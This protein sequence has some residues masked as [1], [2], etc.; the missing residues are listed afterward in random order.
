V[1]CALR[2]K[3]I[4]HRAMELSV[5]YFQKKSKASLS[6]RERLALLSRLADVYIYHLF[7]L[8]LFPL[9]HT[10]C[11]A[12]FQNSPESRTWLCAF[13]QNLKLSK[14]CP[15]EG[16]RRGRVCEKNIYQRGSLSERMWEKSRNETAKHTVGKTEPVSNMSH[17]NQTLAS[18]L[19]ILTPS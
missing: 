8:L 17:A 1:R 16:R 14:T 10:R 11:G 2:K 19:W 7:G 5:R 13:F 3:S 6:Y 4:S 12:D 9:H 18:L 15:C